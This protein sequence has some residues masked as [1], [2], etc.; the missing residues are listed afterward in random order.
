MR[1]KSSAT[2]FAMGVILAT[3]AHADE[4]EKVCK[5]V[6]RELASGPHAHLELQMGTYSPDGKTFQGCVIKFSGDA[7]RIKDTQHAGSLF[8]DTMPYCPNGKPR[9]NALV[10]ENGW[11]DE[12]PT[13]GPD[14]MTEELVKGNMLCKV[15]GDSTGN[16]DDDATY[17]SPNRYDVTVA[18]GHR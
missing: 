12:H 4:L 11:C 6:Y 15:V 14:G 3:N 7:T 13:E 8:G 10:N 1:I 5:K 18:C 9:A 17:I 2:L 16:A